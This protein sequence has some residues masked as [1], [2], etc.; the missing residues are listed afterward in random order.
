VK[1]NRIRSHLLATWTLEEKRK[2]EEKEIDF[3]LRFYRREKPHKK[4]R[5]RSRKGWLSNWSTLSRKGE[6]RLE[7]P[8]T[9]SK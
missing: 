7:T 3:R 9:P 1:K 6:K 2:K 4:G 8:S 5:G